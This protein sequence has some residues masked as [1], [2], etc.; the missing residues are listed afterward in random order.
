MMRPSR[1]VFLQALAAASADGLSRRANA[2]DV[3]VPIGLQC[4]LTGK[5]A[6]FDRAFRARCGP[7]ARLIVVYEDGDSARIGHQMET[8]LQEMPDIAGLSKTVEALEWSSPAALVSA[9][10]ERPTALVYLSVGLDVEAPTI[11]TALGGTMFSPS[12]RPASSPSVALASASS[13]RRESRRYM[14][15]FA[16]RR[17][18]RSILRP[19]CSGS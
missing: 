7:T 3:S 19:S 11:A 4:D 10:R 15:I 14:S 16:S 6:V 2:A 13:W 5:L 18:R 9:V 1:R 12:A 17:R 8:A